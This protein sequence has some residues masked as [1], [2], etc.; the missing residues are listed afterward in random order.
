V[1]LLTYALVSLGLY[2]TPVLGRVTTTFVG[3]WW[4]D[5]RLFCWSLVWWP[6]AITQGQN[7]LF[8]DA[9]WAS[10]GVN[11]AW[12]TTIPGP[13]VVMW[14]VTETFGPIASLNLLHL[15]SPALAGWAAYLVC[16][17][18]TGMFW[19]S[20]A[21]GY[22]FGFS[23]YLLNHM[24]GHPNLTLVFPVPLAVYLVMR[25]MDGSI[26][27]VAFV[28]ALA[29]DLLVLFSIFTE[30]FATLAFFG[31]VALVGAFLFVPTRLRGLLLRTVWLIA[32]AYAITAIVA[33][34]YILATLRGV[35]LNP[36]ANLERGSID[37]FSF[38]IPRDTTL[39]GGAAFKKFTRPF[40]AG[41]IGDGG[42]LGIPLIAV[43]VSFAVSQRARRTTWGLLGFVGVTAI[44]SLGPILHIAGQG[45]I[46]LPWA[47]VESLPLINHATPH[48]L[49]M[50]LWLPIGMIVALWLAARPRSPVRWLVVVVATVAIAPNLSAL[51]YHFEARLPPF[52]S[53][54]IYRRY[55]DPGEV[56][57]VLP[58]GRGHLGLSAHDM[59][60]QAETDMYF[61]LASGYTAGFVPP[62]N[63]A[64]MVRCLREDLP[65]LVR[66]QAFVDY[67]Q[68]QRVETVIVSPGYGERWGPLL[69]LLGLEPTE[70][71]WVTLYALSGP[72]RL[73][74]EAADVPEEPLG[75]PAPDEV[76]GP[77]S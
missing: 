27:P 61:R 71:G 63:R 21:G 29:A 28:A 5:P 14:P 10:T 65:H 19:P 9:I 57:L 59:Y 54:G 55:L 23:T 22:F 35:P 40:T 67:L 25:R 12:V 70:A 13:S 74:P 16:R 30:T 34:P 66:P 72:G 39:V 69:S 42:Y 20:L 53:E 46:D 56:V 41:S 15:A 18:A 38:V 62:G 48:R 17:R 8:S 33:L 58:L 11:L 76:G 44:A 1:A 26:G 7:P 2:G 52:F 50:Y 47:M 37:L 24:T 3:T 43:A 68:Q 45:T 51:P 64:R 31:F 4:H 73:P 49:T 36:L 75:S 6:H 32:A 77:C 60:W